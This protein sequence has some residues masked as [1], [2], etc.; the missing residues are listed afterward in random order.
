MCYLAENYEDEFIATAGNSGLIFSGQ[1][2]AIETASMLSDVGLNISQ[3]QQ[4]SHKN[5]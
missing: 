2:P 1:M 4:V 5:V 3:L